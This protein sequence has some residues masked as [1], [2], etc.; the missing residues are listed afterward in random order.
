METVNGIYSVK[1]IVENQEV[2]SVS[3]ES[4]ACS[5]INAN[6]DYVS[7]SVDNARN[8]LLYTLPDTIPG[9]E[10]EHLAALNRWGLE[11]TTKLT[12]R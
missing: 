12:R 4:E 9:I 10:L 1:A 2:T 11:K 3:I 7:V 8:Y 5:E 6:P